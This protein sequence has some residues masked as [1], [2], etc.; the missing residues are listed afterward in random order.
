MDNPVAAS[1]SGDALITAVPGLALAVQVADCQAILIYDPVRRV[2]ANVHSG[3]R[4]SINE[5][6]SK[7]VVAMGQKFGCRSVDMV[8]AIGPSLGLC[9]AEFVNYRTE[10]PESL[11]KY[12][13]NTNHFDFWKISRDQL[14]IGGLKPQKYP[15]RGTVHLLSDGFIFF[16]SGG[17]A[18]YG[19]V[20]R[21]YRD[22]AGG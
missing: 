17:S 20:C 8:A 3:W 18:A 2:V 22:A 5:I 19:P 12:K 6:A 15:Y 21:G 10:I 9:C 14:V 11:W 1:R 7:T 16:L 13:D 4:G